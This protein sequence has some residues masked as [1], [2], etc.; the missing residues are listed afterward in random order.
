MGSAANQGIQLQ[1][2][3]P[4]PELVDKAFARMLAE[5]PEFV[6]LTLIMKLRTTRWKEALLHITQVR[7]TAMKSAVLQQF[8][9]DLKDISGGHIDQ[10]LLDAIIALVQAST[11]DAPMVADCREVLSH[12]QRMFSGVML[13]RGIMIALTQP[14]A[15]GYAA[16][17][18]LRETLDAWSQTHPDKHLVKT[19]EGLRNARSGVKKAADGTFIDEGQPRFTPEYVERLR[20]FIL[21]RK[22]LSEQMIAGLRFQRLLELITTWAQESDAARKQA[23]EAMIVRRSEERANQL[24]IALLTQRL[25]ACGG[26]QGAEALERTL[27]EF[28]A[29][30]RARLRR[31][32]A[33]SGRRI[34][35]LMSLVQR[36]SAPDTNSDSDLMPLRA[37]LDLGTASAQLPEVAAALA[38][39]MQPQLHTFTDVLVLLEL[40]EAS[41][42]GLTDGATNMFNTLSRCY[43]E[44]CSTY[45]Y[46][47]S[48][49]LRSST[50]Q[51]SAEAI[52]G[53]AG[54]LAA[55]R[56]DR[57]KDL[58]CF[59]LQ[60][61]T[62][63]RTQAAFFNDPY[64]IRRLTLL[65]A[66]YR[67]WR[68]EDRIYRAAAATEMPMGPDAGKTFGNPDAPR[69]R[70]KRKLQTRRQTSSLTEQ[71]VGKRGVRL[72]QSWLL[73]EEVI[74]ETLEHL[75]VL[76]YPR[77]N[78]N[79]R[80]RL[81]EQAPHPF[82]KNRKR[83]W[84]IEGFR[85]S[86]DRRSQYGTR[87]ALV[88][89]SKEQW[90][91][92]RNQ[93]FELKRYHTQFAS[94]QVQVQRFLEDAPPSFPEVRE[95]SIDP[96]WLR[97]LP[98]EA[99]STLLSDYAECYAHYRRTLLRL[100]DFRPVRGPEDE[101]LTPE[102]LFDIE[103]LAA[104][105]FLQAAAR[106]HPVVGQPISYSRTMG[107][108]YDALSFAL[109]TYEQPRVWGGTNTRYTLACAFCGEEAPERALLNREDTS[110]RAEQRMFV[111]APSQPFLP[112]RSVDAA[113]MYFALQFGAKHQARQLLETLWLQRRREAT[114]AG[115]QMTAAVTQARLTLGRDADGYRAWFAHFPVPIQAAEVK[116]QPE[117]AMGL[118]EHRGEYFFAT[119]D[120]NGQVR[121][122]G[123]I[124]LPPYFTGESGMQSEHYPFVLAKM[125]IKQS[126]QEQQ[127]A[128]IGI[129]NTDWK[130]T[131]SGL[132]RAENRLAFAHPRQRIIEVLT[133]KAAI[134]GILRPMVVRNVAPSRDCGQCGRRMERSAIQLAPTRHCF[135]CATLGRPH[136]LRQVGQGRNQTLCCTVCGQ[137]WSAREPVFRCDRCRIRQ[138]ARV[139]TAL[140]VARKLLE[141]ITDQRREEEEEVSP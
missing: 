19:L 82:W 48:A 29:Q 40:G 80:I 72:L 94:I 14:D 20:W 9:R 75:D 101:D 16:L 116:R 103:T 34:P 8:Q 39:W 58:G 38:Q 127:S 1:L 105:E 132:D 11:T 50:F 65:P 17:G 118:H 44:Y 24:C 83:K 113:L 95:M 59:P 55:Y 45:E 138:H 93:L 99:T 46:P 97:S 136:A 64:R 35:L 68:D 30:E 42:R 123:K 61:G 66:L 98:E 135:H 73:P 87:V 77:N 2:M 57:L 85:P 108:N 69:Q 6:Y 137:I 110:Q 134:E 102:R 47:L 111:N 125:I 60:L 21:L 63:K 36:L 131:E 54:K 129:E 27:L 56:I 139:N 76:L 100:R 79:E 92:L 91:M 109:L 22:R 130:R 32:P 25:A 5:H 128:F 53:W 4:A 23:L 52:I 89:L 124:D 43:S 117:V 114:N 81:A 18:G 126:D 78:T 71:F 119:I 13:L 90:L 104:H 51:D 70:Q 31:Q 28:L 107:V 141:Q 67:Y 3:P 10:R 140:V 49:A 26:A 15:D 86:Q 121:D 122:V 74:N 84:R 115:A 88:S 7:Y 37:Q 12:L 33:P 41:D 112:S 96:E 120:F 133:Y 106:L 62:R